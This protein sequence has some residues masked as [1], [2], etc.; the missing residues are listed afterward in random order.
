MRAIFAAALVAG[1]LAAGSAEA[2]RSSKYVTSVTFD[3]APPEL[4][5]EPLALRVKITRVRD[6]GAPRRNNRAYAWARVIGVEKGAYRARTVRIALAVNS[7]GP[8]PK[9]GDTGLIVGH[10]DTAADGQP[11]F[12]PQL[13][14]PAERDA[15]KKNPRA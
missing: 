12:T 2:C 8:F 11:V 13:D 14:S 10:L 6:T 1:M 3:E 7:C 4:A 15:R 9:V 5:Y